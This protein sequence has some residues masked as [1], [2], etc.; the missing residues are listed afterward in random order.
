MAPLWEGQ[1]VQGA[2]AVWDTCCTLLR[3]VQGDGELN[4]HENDPQQAAVGTH[5]VLKRCTEHPSKPGAHFYIKKRTINVIGEVNECYEQDTYG[6][7]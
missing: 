5:S 2:E 3:S 6:Y 4:T 1:V 7:Q